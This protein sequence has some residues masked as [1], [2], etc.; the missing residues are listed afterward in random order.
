VRPFSR[1]SRRGLSRRLSG[2]VVHHPCVV[3][4]V[5]A[6]AFLP[7]YCLARRRKLKRYYGA[8]AV[9]G[10]TSWAKPGESERPGSSEEEDTT[11]GRVKPFGVGCTAGP[12][13]KSARRGAP[14]FCFLSA[15]GNARYNHP[16]EM[17]ATRLNPKCLFDISDEIHGVL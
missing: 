11:G 12:F 4:A 16:L 17:L 15:V 5:T 1:F 6:T 9:F 2:R 14:P 8:G 3:R 13:S 7:R 10:R